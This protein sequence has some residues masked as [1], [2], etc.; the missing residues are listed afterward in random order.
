MEKRVVRVDDGLADV[1]RVLRHIL[2]LPSRVD[3]LGL[4]QN[5]VTE[6]RGDNLSWTKLLREDKD[7]LQAE[8]RECGFQIS[9]ANK[10]LSLHKL[11]YF[12]TKKENIVTIGTGCVES[13]MYVAQQI[14]RRG[15]PYEGSHSGCYSR[16][17]VNEEWRTICD[18]YEVLPFGTG[19]FQFFCV[20]VTSRTSVLAV[21]SPSGA[22]RIVRWASPAVLHAAGRGQQSTF[23]FGFR[24]REFPEKTDFDS[25]EARRRVNP[26][27]E[28]PIRT[29][30]QVAHVCH[31]R[32]R[33]TLEFTL[34]PGLLGYKRIPK[35]GEIFLLCI[36]DNDLALVVV[37]E[38]GR[39]RLVKRGTYQDVAGLEVGD[40]EARIPRIGQTASRRLERG[41]TLAERLKTLQAPM[42]LR[43]HLVLADA[44]IASGTPGKYVFREIIVALVNLFNDGCVTS[45]TFTTRR[46][47][48]FLSFWG[49]IGK[50]M[51]R[52]ERRKDLWR[53]SAQ[54][55]MVL[56]ETATPFVERLT[57]NSHRRLFKFDEFAHPSKE[58][59][60]KIE[61]YNARF[62]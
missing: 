42:V 13:L 19:G 43:D 37:G 21:V 22:F 17:V 31:H 16:N 6:Q 36:G 8:H 23:D 52:G 5:Q 44:A 30:R 60:E 33:E 35:V 20:P 55:A 40:L 18:R 12:W 2:G 56:L 59:L 41:E 24:V 58:M 1:E 26:S 49:Y 54:K 53:D 39:R 10:V 38:N 45:Q 46:L 3:V 51:G 27:I 34:V 62:R 50:E 47:I 32:A 48:S 57:P 29:S 9:P 7:V 61:E 11:Q 28:Q 14:V 15:G 25:Y 4:I